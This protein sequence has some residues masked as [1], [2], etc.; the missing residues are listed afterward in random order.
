MVNTTS[1]IS[2]WVEFISNNHPPQDENVI[3]NVIVD[4]C[5]N[6]VRRGDIAAKQKLVVLKVF[7][8]PVPI[9][10]AAF[11]MAWLLV[12]IVAMWKERI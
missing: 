4:P 6:H 9:G 5:F 2:R 7:A 10:G 12:A 8:M 1:A 11:I 3:E